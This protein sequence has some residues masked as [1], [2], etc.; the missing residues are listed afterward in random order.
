MSEIQKII[1]HYPKN[2][3]VSVRI[4]VQYLSETS[5]N[6]PWSCSGNIPRKTTFEWFAAHVIPYYRFKYFSDRTCS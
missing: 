1:M 6:F 4:D 3:P 2:F 5:Q